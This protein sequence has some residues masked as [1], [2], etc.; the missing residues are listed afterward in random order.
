MTEYVERTRTYYLVYNWKK[1]DI[2]IRKTEP[3]DDD[4]GPNEVAIENQLNIRVPEL[5]LHTIE[6]DID[7]PE[8]RVEKAAQEAALEEQD[9]RGTVR[10][11]MMDNEDQLSPWDSLSDKDQLNV[12]DYL[13]SKV[14][15]RYHGPVDWDDAREVIERE[16]ADYHDVSPRGVAHR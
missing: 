12:I 2:K 8:A 6:T 7:I 5:D 11:V 14:R 13:L 4:L 15:G 16:I 10:E 3:S 1:D 9:L